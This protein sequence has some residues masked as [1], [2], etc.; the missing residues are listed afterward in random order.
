MLIEIVVSYQDI[1]ELYCT[2]F[3]RLGGP[4]DSY[5]STLLMIVDKISCLF[6]YFCRM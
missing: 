2:F 5:E 1:D 4:L 3:E 6:A